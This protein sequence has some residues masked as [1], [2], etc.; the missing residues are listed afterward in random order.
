[1]AD[2][3]QGKINIFTK[4]TEFKTLNVLNGVVRTNAAGGLSS[5]TSV[6][7]DELTLTNLETDNFKTN[8]IDTDVDLSAD[9]DT[10]LA[11]QKATKAY[12]DNVL[13]NA[14]VT[15]P[16]LPGST[17]IRGQWSYAS[18]YLYQCIDTDTW[19]RWAVATTWT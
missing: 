9:S 1:M 11:T 2:L 10:R 14:Y 6:D 16:A 7:V 17:G 12:A 3:G 19:V 13:Q 5:S 15:A 18:G 4:A 8:V